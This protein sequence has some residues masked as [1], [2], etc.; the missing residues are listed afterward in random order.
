MGNWKVNIMTKKQI[1]EIRNALIEEGQKNATKY[2]FHLGE[3]IKF[4]PTQVEE[5]LS[6]YCNDDCFCYVIRE[7]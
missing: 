2:G 4:T 7:F 1:E 5:I 6:K 3:T